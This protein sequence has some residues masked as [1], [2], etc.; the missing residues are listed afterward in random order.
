MFHTMSTFDQLPLEGKQKAT[1]TK[2]KPSE[3]RNGDKERKNVRT[4]SCNKQICESR[5][6][7]VFFF[8]LPPIIQRKHRIG[9]G[10]LL[11]RG[12][13]SSPGINS[14]QSAPSAPPRLSL[15]LKRR[16]RKNTA[17]LVGWV[18][19]SCVFPGG[20]RYPVLTGRLGLNRVVLRQYAV[21]GPEKKSGFLNYRALG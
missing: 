21:L 6:G 4:A 11:P 10:A 18:G 8:S 13:R 12:R 3:T 20:P 17:K 19:R 16:C 1:E 9:N 15:G 14:A 5:G 2:K 7:T